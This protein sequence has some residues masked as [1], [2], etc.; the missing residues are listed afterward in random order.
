MTPPARA[1]GREPPVHLLAKEPHWLASRLSLLGS[2]DPSPENGPAM[3]LAHD[4]TAWL[5]GGQAQCIHQPGH[6][7]GEPWRLVLLGAPGVGK[8]TQAAL[9]CER[10]MA[11]HLSTGDIFR[12]AKAEPGGPKTPALE[13]ALECMRKGELVPDGTVLALVTERTRC[14]RCGGG[15]VL[16]GFPRTVAQ[17]ESLSLLLRKEA[18]GLTAAINYELPIDEIVARLSG[19]RVCPKCKAVYHLAGHPP[20]KEGVC[21]QCGTA[22]EQRED[23]RP[24]AIR[25]RMR[26]YEESAQP[27]VDYYRRAGLLI[28]VPAYG[29]PEEIYVRT[30]RLTA[31]R[32]PDGYRMP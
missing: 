12:A 31:G 32:L 16:D 10:L 11:C 20:K 26:V 19:R 24:E 9:L 6:P 1:A 21:D 28:S 8:G 15:F 3:N 27:V 7:A 14:L 5:K 18:I 30:K 29:T 4:R 25:V 17:A 2:R 22:L 23:D 13:C